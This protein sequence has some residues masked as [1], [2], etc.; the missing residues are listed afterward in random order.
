LAFSS[1]YVTR[2]INL[3][4]AAYPKTV[5]FFGLRKIH[6][7]HIYQYLDC[8]YVSGLDISAAV[9]PQRIVGGAYADCQEHFANIVATSCDDAWRVFLSIPS[10]AGRL[11][12]VLNNDGDPIQEVK[13]LIK[14]HGADLSG[15]LL[16]VDFSRRGDL[17]RLL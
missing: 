15:V 8:A 12:P 17:S 4:L 14:N 3:F 7:A 5:S 16:D 6:P 1:S 9:V 10:D 11:F 2:M 13:R